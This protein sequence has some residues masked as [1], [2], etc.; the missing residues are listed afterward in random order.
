[1]C[2]A[3]GIASDFKPSLKEENGRSHFCPEA[4]RARRNL[5]ILYADYR[6]GLINM[7]SMQGESISLDGL[8]GV[9]HEGRKGKG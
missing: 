1:M 3:G 8:A 2:R 5:Q 4:C 7:Q 9:S 6:T